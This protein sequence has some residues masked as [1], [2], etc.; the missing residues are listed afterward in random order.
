MGLGTDGGAKS[1]A[2]WQSGR[3]RGPGDKD[4]WN[5]GAGH[6]AKRKARALREY[7]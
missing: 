1:Q 7:K 6:D 5:R 4:F 3:P 2:A